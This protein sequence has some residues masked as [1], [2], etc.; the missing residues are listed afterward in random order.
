MKCICTREAAER[1]TVNNWTRFN[2]KGDPQKIAN[3]IENRIFNMKDKCYEADLPW[4][5]YDYGAT[6]EQEMKNHCGNGGERNTMSVGVLGNPKVRNDLIH[7]L[8]RTGQYNNGFQEQFLDKFCDRNGWPRPDAFGDYVKPEAW[9]QRYEG[10]LKI[11][12]DISLPA[13]TK[14]YCARMAIKAANETQDEQHWMLNDFKSD[15]VILEEAQRNHMSGY[16]FFLEF[17]KK[18]V[19]TVYIS[20]AIINKTREWRKH[21]FHLMS[22]GDQHK[23]KGKGADGEEFDWD[24]YYCQLAM[25]TEDP[26][27]ERGPIDMK[28]KGSGKPEAKGKGK[29][30]KGGGEKGEKGE[31]GKEGKGQQEKGKPVRDRRGWFPYVFDFAMVE[32]E[33]TEP[34]TFQRFIPWCEVWNDAQRDIYKT[35]KRQR[36]T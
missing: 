2:T 33:P 19:C 7:Y 24:E 8:K 17:Q 31:K 5:T 32:D 25:V 23:G 21:F 11:R 15:C 27:V 10:Q 13:R 14:G 26:E 4:Y 34:N 6:L 35:N 16:V 28:G 36:R 22:L 18:G 1:Y 20:R 3:Q 9:L 29:K 12:A 30:G